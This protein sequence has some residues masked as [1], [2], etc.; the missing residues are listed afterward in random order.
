MT[1]EEVEKYIYQIAFSGAEEF[2]NKYKDKDSKNSIIGHFG[3][4]FYSSFMVSDNVE[5]L[6]KSQIPNSKAVKWSCDGSPNYNMEEISKKTKGTDVVLHI[7]EDSTEFLEES[8]LT[9]ILNKYCKFL[10]VEIKFGQKSEFID[11]PKGKKDKD[12]NVEKIEK[13]VDNI[14]NNTKPAWTK[15]PANL[16]ENHY[17][18]F[19]KELY[20]MEFNDPL[21]HIHLNVD[22]PFNLTGILYFP[23]LK[24]N[25]EVQK[26]K[27]NLY[28]NQ[29]FITDN[30]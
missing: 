7:S 16:K 24:N 12:G 6:T 1:G 15:R 25:L 19:Y 4:G 8:R 30:V 11:D 28:S 26:N 5:I 2:V 21:F 27:I 3:L 10:P 17:K 18:E 14:I 13:K 20:P 9:T 23:K 29:V 22:F